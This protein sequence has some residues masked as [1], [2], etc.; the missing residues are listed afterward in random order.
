ME[1]TLM[2]VKIGPRAVRI[3]AGDPKTHVSRI[4]HTT[5][6]IVDQY[7]EVEY[8]YLYEH[9]HPMNEMEAWKQFGDIC[10]QE[11]EVAMDRAAVR[12]GVEAIAANGFIGDCIIGVRPKATENDSQL[13]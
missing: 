8:A 1:M 4:P 5:V 3:V 10:R 13:A 7:G 11:A 2:E 6:E 9:T 12:H